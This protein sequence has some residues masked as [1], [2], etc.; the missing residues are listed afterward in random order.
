MAP[1]VNTIRET[2]PG[3][4]AVLLEPCSC[5][6]LRHVLRPQAGSVVWLVAYHP[7]PVVEWVDMRLP[8]TAG[9]ESEP[10]RARLPR[11]DL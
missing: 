4:F 11:Y 7:H 8:L 9:G 6:M 1:T 2:A 3:V 10:V 5:Q